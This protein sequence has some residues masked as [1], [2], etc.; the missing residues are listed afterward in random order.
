[1]VDDGLMASKPLTDWRHLSRDRL[2]EFENAHG[3]VSGGRKNRGRRYLTEQLNHA[4][5]VALAAH[6]QKFCR[7]LHTE[8]TNHLANTI[9]NRGVQ[10]AFLIVMIQGRKLDVG[11]ANSANITADFNRI[12]MVRIFDELEQFNRLNKTRQRRLDQLV[13]WRNAIGHQDFLFTPPV[14]AR[15]QGTKPT[16]VWVRTWRSALDQL[17]GDLDEVV[18]AHLGRVVGVHPW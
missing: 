9:A 3:A 1:M 2:D 8:A 18:V 14:L 15:L 13:T 10:Q 12:G 16:L 17:A 4:Y 6:F 11:N 7:D 5:L